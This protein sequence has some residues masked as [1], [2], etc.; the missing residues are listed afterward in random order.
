MPNPLW[1]AR[2]GQQK[3]GGGRGVTVPGVILGSLRAGFFH[4]LLCGRLSSDSNL[5]SSLFSKQAAVTQHFRA[6]SKFVAHPPGVF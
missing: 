6:R 3:R 2:A 4:C 1:R 5:I